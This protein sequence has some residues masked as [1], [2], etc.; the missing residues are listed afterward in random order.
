[1]L[2]LKNINKSYVSS[3]KN[4]VDALTNINLAFETKGLTFILGASGSGKS[5]LLN[6][7]GGLDT[8]TSGDIFINNTKLLDDNSSLDLYRNNYISFIFQDFN[9][10]SNLTVYEN[11][12]LVYGSL[13]TDSVKE[14]IAKILLQVNLSG[15]EDR[16]PSELSGGEIQR[17]AIARALAKDSAII[18]ADEPTGN[19]N[20]ENSENICEILK[21]IS[22]D[23]LVI[24]VSH[25]EDLAS[26]YAD[27]VIKIEDGKVIKDIIVNQINN[28]NKEFIANNQKFS[29][30]NIFK[31]S[32][33]NLF[34]R[35]IRFIIS[36]VSIVLAFSILSLSLAIS[37][38]ER[39]YVDAKNIT[40][41]NVNK[42][43]I[44]SNRDNYWI[45][46]STAEKITEYPELEYIRNGIVE[47]IND[48]INMGYELYPNYQEITDE[49]IILSDSYL[50]GYVQSGCLYYISNNQEVA[51][52]EF[53]FERINEYYITET[54]NYYIAGVY[55]TYSFNNDDVYI[56]DPQTESY[57]K[58]QNDLSEKI[59]FRTANSLYRYIYPYFMI[60]NEKGEF[61]LK[62]KQDNLTR[63]ITGLENSIN[64]YY[65]LAGPYFNNQE[66]VANG[67][68]SKLQENEIYVS[69]DVYN[70]IFNEKS[71]LA[72]YLGDNYFERKLIRVPLHINEQLD[73][74]IIENS[75]S[76]EK[77]VLK[78]VAI[79]GI[80][81]DCDYRIIMSEGIGKKIDN[82]TINNSIL[83]KTSSIKNQ[84]S[85]L[86]PIYD[87]YGYFAN[88]YYT[89]RLT[90]FEE[91]LEIAKVVSKILVPLMIALIVLINTIIISQIVKSKDKENGV[92]RAIGVRKQSIIN[93]YLLQSI[94]IICISFVISLIIAIVF[95]NLTNNA[96][97]GEYSKSISVLL[98]RWQY[99]LVI[100]ILTVVVNLVISYLS[101]YKAISK[102]PIDVIKQKV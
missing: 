80:L 93:I 95:I 82:F 44:T 43:L 94:L 7:I 52:T 76:E 8:P 31:L 90:S 99:A 6:L 75:S 63:T 36:M 9:L 26:R 79:K 39:P 54:E 57:D 10:L 72:Y 45:Y 84:Y 50:N 16:Y 3:K 91:D 53:S 17:I 100:I 88:Y 2:E 61:T 12:S 85:F 30:K 23:K 78:N 1:M 14:K 74:E 77:L 13:T 37:G 101:L 46:N 89:E 102:N 34:D 22:L 81:V 66:Y 27:K 97:V 47:S 35:K 86:K 28:D 60:G 64:T 42:Y 96:L 19:L 98:F 40:S 25:N 49:S 21:T 62:V 59:L 18:L 38:F 11:I 58:A 67:A 92:L 48:V 41:N 4:R 55:H 87:D 69:L 20:K 73:L 51:K 56:N 68:G 33:K 5:T 15:Y 65:H 83:V 29:N 32:L 70:S 71:N 24:V